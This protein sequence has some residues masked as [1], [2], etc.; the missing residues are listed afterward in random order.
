MTT[1]VPYQLLLPPSQDDAGTLTG[2]EITPVS[3]SS[4]I[5]GV[6]L[7]RI[8]Q[9]LLPTF[10]GFNVK[11]YGAKGDGV[12][13]DTSA[14]NAALAAANAAGGTVYFPAGVYICSG[15]WNMANFSNVHLR[16][17]GG[18]FQGG[19]ALGTMIKFTQSGSTSCINNTGGIGCSF[20]DIV[21]A[22]TSATYTGTL[23]DASVAAPHNI[24]QGKI[25][26]CQF[27]QLGTSNSAANLVAINNVSGYVIDNCIFARASCAIRGG[28]NGSAGAS[29]AVTVS[30]CEISFCDSAIAN[31]NNFWTILRTS[32]EPSATNAPTQIFND[33]SNS[34]ANLTII[35]CFFGDVLNTGTHLN[36]RA[37][38]N[39]L[40]IGSIF[41]GDNVHVTTA[42]AL[43][44]A[45]TGI[46]ITGNT[47]VQLN[48]AIA[49]SGTVSGGK[50]S[51]N[52]FSS[53][54]TPLFGR[55]SASNFNMSGNSGFITEAAGTATITAGTT[56]VVVNHGLAVTPGAGQI[57][58]TPAGDTL[59]A[60]YWLASWTATQFTININA[61][62]ASN[63]V[64]YW[65]ANVDQ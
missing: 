6:T 11:V 45:N 50:L 23:L 12:T 62:Q 53:T 51:G 24:T 14:I 26:G 33:A 8:A 17:A 31:P 43:A 60:R 4:A 30:N 47:F 39:L 44:G 22:Y 54:T 48:T 56:T 36:L 13:D 15:Q 32:F 41:G 42:L 28:W 25:E 63:I 38:T 49:I 5:F 21:F 20:R 18:I 3:R 40:I 19:N 59:G 10:F 2:A 7:L 34:I 9:W 1:K 29:N 64:L 55:A 61:T 46:V 35:G 16:G 65:H 37:V 52:V 27:L 58:L 57:K